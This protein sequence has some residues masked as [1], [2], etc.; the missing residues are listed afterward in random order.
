MPEALIHFII[1]LFLI[2]TI[3]INLRN[4]ILISSLAV[5]PDA[6]I[7]FGVHR[8]ISHSVF[9]LLAL[10]TV[11]ILILD[12]LKVGKM[13]EKLLVILVLLSHPFLDMFGGFTPILWPIFD[14]SVYVFTQLTTNM[15]NILDLNLIFKVNLERTVFSRVDGDGPIFTSGG[16]AIT[17]V[18]LAGFAMKDLSIRAIRA[19]GM[20]NMARCGIVTIEKIFRNKF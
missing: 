1:P 19:R 16:F 6:D 12:Y 4:S 20:R 14:K 17:L 13:S 15:G 9:F 10:G 2:L 18:L 8:S 5:I 3:G 7:I 11:I